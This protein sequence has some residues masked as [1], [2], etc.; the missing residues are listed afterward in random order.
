MKKKRLASGPLDDLH[1]GQPHPLGEANGRD[2]VFAGS[3]LAL[4]FDAKVSPVR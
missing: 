4:P 1:A 3:G 2:L